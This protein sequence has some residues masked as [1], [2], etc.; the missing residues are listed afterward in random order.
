MPQQEAF[1]EQR[2]GDRRIEVLKTYDRN[3]AYQA[4]S[5]MDDDAQTHLWNALGI[6]E[7]YDPAD[8]PNLADPGSG[9]FLWDE[10]L[11]AAREDGNI[12]SFF[13]VKES[14][15]PGSEPLYVSPDWPSAESFAKTRI[16]NPS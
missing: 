16:L 13:V 15:S 5:T 1:L 12:L 10:L 8:V 2:S 11:D 4:F 6:G 14:S 7:D 9:D 3:F